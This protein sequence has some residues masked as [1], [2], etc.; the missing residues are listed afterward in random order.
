MFEGFGTF[1]L[2]AYTA[3]GAYPV[4][5]ALVRLQS[6]NNPAEVIK[7]SLI[8]DE[9]GATQRIKLPAPSKDISL[10]PNGGEV[11]YATYNVEISCDGYYSKQILN[12][13]I[14]DGINAT[15]PVSM[16]PFIP[17]SE[18]GRYPRGNVNAIITENKS[19]E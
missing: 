18:G 7:R 2:R 12:V 17:Y 11:P 8:T 16:I 19:L 13:A 6:T 5:G 4:P 10:D 14:F 3:G 9:D 1:A 15:L